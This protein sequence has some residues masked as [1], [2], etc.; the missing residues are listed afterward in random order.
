MQVGDLVKFRYIYSG[1][2]LNDKKALYLGEDFIHRVDGV[3]VYNHKILEIG[4]TKPTIIDVGL[5]K[6]MSVVEPI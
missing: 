5:L 4:A 1:C 2:D 6:Y 3:T